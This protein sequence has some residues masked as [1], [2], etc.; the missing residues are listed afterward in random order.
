MSKFKKE[1]QAQFEGQTA[2]DIVTR[3]EKIAHQGFKSQIGALNN[4]LIYDE[5]ALDDAIAVRKRIVY[6]NTMISNVDQYMDNYANAEKKVED[7]RASMELTKSSIKFFQE[8]M[9]EEFGTE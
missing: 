4:K 2:N 3:N 9:E 1:T 6:P 5:I 7:A 8:K